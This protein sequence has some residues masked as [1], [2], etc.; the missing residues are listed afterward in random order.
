M[1]R[2]TVAIATTVLMAGIVYAAGGALGGGGLQGSPPAPSVNGAA[3]TP[4]SISTGL[5]D[6]GQLYVANQT[7]SAGTITGDATEAFRISLAT[8]RIIWSNS[9]R[10]LTVNEASGR[11]NFAALELG[12]VSD[13]TPLAI[14]GDTTS[15]ARAAFK[16]VP[17]DA[18]P[19]GANTVGDMYVTTA[20]VLKICTVAGTPGTWVSVG[21]Q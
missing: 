18:E 16:L 11:L 19:T 8:G 3:I 6:A 9:G 17:Q 14:S 10:Y 7:T 12:V 15:P 20:G 4:S 5:I 2:F 21:A 13:S 1:K